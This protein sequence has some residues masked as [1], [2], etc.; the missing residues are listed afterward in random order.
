MKLFF[1]QNLYCN[2]F[3]CKIY[4]KINMKLVWWLNMVIMTSWES[5][6]GYWIPSLVLALAW[7][8]SEA[9]ALRLQLAKLVAYDCMRQALVPAQ[10]S[11]QLCGVWIVFSEP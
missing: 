1:L 11:N 10:A 4:N 7:P 2:S 5:K 8:L 3:V 9:R 6:K